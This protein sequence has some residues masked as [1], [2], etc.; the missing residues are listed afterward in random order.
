[1][2][3]QN[4][5]VARRWTELFNDRSD[6]TE[7]LSLIAADV[8]MQTPTGARVRGRE[9]ARA[10][11]EK[12][13]DNVRPRIIADRFVGSGDTVVG[14]GRSQMQWIESGETSDEF[15]SAAVF[16]FRDGKI[17]TWQPFESHAAALEAAGLLEE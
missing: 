17:V 12:S 1:M 8:E 10:W 9:E 11:F 7:F 15:E 5:A 14:L 6:V 16:R 2:S 3:E 4:V 13:F